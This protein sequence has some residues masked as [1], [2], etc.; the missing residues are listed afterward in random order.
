MVPLL[1]FITGAFSFF[2]Y[3]SH[4]FINFLCFIIQNTICSVKNKANKIKEGN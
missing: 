3:F 1:F 4:I 2:V